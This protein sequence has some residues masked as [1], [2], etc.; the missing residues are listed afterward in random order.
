M[1]T[2]T[3]CHEGDWFYLAIQE[4]TNSHDYVH[5]DKIHERWTGMNADPDWKQY[6]YL[7]GICPI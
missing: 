2:W 1:N 4:A 5:K 3:D 7:G 6:E